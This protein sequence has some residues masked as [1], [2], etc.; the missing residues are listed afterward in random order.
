MNNNYNIFYKT[1]NGRFCMLNSITDEI[2]TVSYSEKPV[3]YCFNMLNYGYEA[4]HEDLRRFAKDFKIWDE[5][6]RNNNVLKIFWTSYYNNNSAVRLTFQRLSKGKYEHHDPIEK[7]EAEWMSKTHNGALTYC[8]PQI[9]QS[10]GYDYSLFYPRIMSGKN[11]ILPNKCGREI[12]INKLPPI[13]KIPFGFYRVKI[14]CDDDNF[15]KIFAFSRQNTYLDKSLYQAMKHK[16][17]F[18]VKIEL[19]EDGK[20]NAYVYDSFETGHDVLGNWYNKITQLRALFPKNI[21]IKFLASSLSGQLSSRF[22]IKK[23]YDEIMD[24][25]IDVGLTNDHK[26]VIVDKHIYVDKLGNKKDYY[27]LQ[28]TDNPYSYNIRLMPFLTSYARNK[29]ARLALKDIDS[30]IRIHT[31]SVC[32]S[33]QQEFTNKDKMLDYSTLIPE[34]KS[35]GIID[36]Q[37]MNKYYNFTYELNKLKNSSKLIDSMINVVSSLVL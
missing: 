35:T 10:Y 15:K 14:T 2:T 4:S 3:R 36:W 37:H 16:D 17:K 13:E 11:F 27:D 24:E 22:I 8:E 7:T 12:T 30:V 26:Y 20:P 23:S 34:S 19:I 18:N 9:T 21:L 28:N 5:Q 33:K 6:L 25:K 32:F 29:I 31:D 1:S